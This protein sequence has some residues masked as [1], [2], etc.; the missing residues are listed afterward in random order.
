VSIWKQGQGIEGVEPDRSYSRFQKFLDLGPGRRLIDLAKMLSVSPQAIQQ[1]AKR[2]NWIERAHAYD[3][4]TAIDGQVPAVPPR[5]KNPGRRLRRSEASEEDARSGP[6]RQPKAPRGPAVV[7]TPEVLDQAA[8]TIQGGDHLKSLEQYRRVYEQIGSS[9]AGEAREILP[10]IISVRQDM[11]RARVLWR[12]L[13]DQGDAGS[14]AAVSRQVTELIPSYC[15][16]C[17]AMQKM[18]EGG[19]L[20]WGEAI[21]VHGLL[22]RAFGRQG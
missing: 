6:V 8:A 2:F 13:L 17:E 20:H 22:E 7:V 15:R 4:E 11:E 10:V 3:L 18:A 5:P 12:S 9:M 16:L 19:R 14:A 21:G 1:S